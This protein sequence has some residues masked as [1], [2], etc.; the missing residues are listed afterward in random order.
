MG[1]SVFPEKADE[2][3]CEK[4]LPEAYQSIID[5]G[6]VEPGMVLHDSL[7]RHAVCKE[8]E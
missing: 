1:C 8:P 2:K 4:V 3:E 5:D 7:M 6:L